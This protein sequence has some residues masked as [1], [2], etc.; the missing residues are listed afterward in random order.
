MLEFRGA[1]MET[2]PDAGV[3]DEGSPGLRVARTT[4]PSRALRRLVTVFQLSPAEESAVDRTR[5]TSL[6]LDVMITCAKPHMKVCCVCRVVVTAGFASEWP[7]C[8]SESELC[9]ASTPSGT[10][11]SLRVAAVP[12]APSPP[13]LTLRSGC[14]TAESSADSSKC[15][16][17]RGVGVPH[18]QNY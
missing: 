6:V 14:V 17:Q 9:S 4:V 18:Y 13:W 10:C 7:P 8:P 16:S 1:A 12:V 2:R 3:E 5:D 11:E 15:T